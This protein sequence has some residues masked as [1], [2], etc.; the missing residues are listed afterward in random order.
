MDSQQELHTQNKVFDVNNLKTI[1][2][3]SYCGNSYYS[4]LLLAR[5]CIFGLKKKQ[6]MLNFKFF[7]LRMYCDLPLMS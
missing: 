1:R 6:Q 5:S 4:S 2:V 7:F 3:F